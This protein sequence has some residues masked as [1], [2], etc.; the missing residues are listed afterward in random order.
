MFTKLGYM[1]GDYPP[2]R[3]SEPFGNCTYGNSSL[4]PYIAA[5]NIILSH[6]IAVDIYRKSYQVIANSHRCCALK[7]WYLAEVL[8][9]T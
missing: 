9:K 2:S 4:E 5:H 1:S 6:A 8:E 3:C 7:S